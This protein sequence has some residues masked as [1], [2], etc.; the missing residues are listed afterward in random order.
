MAA[1]IKDDLDLDAELLMGSGGIFEV[2][3]DGKVVSAKSLAGFPGE[4]EVVDALTRALDE[5]KSGP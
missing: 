4:W 1:A 5:R 3:L 2:A